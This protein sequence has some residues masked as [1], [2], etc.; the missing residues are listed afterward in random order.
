MEML[1]HGNQV[2]S[3]GHMR[4]VL[5][6]RIRFP[7]QH[8]PKK[9]YNKQASEVSQLYSINRHLNVDEY[10]ASSQ[11]LAMARLYHKEARPS[12]IYT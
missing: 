12:I 3:R 7:S 2:L 8:P 10:F 9:W 6:R 1:R 4:R 5:I 11:E